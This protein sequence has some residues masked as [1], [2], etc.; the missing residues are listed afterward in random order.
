MAAWG[1][2]ISFLVLKKYCTHSLCS[3]VKYF[4][5]LKEKF[6]IS[7]RQCTILYVYIFFSYINITLSLNKAHWKSRTILQGNWKLWIKVKKGRRKF[8]YEQDLFTLS[9]RFF[10]TQEWTEKATLL[11]FFFKMVLNRIL[12]SRT[13]NVS[14]YRTIQKS[15]FHKKELFVKTI[16]EKCNNYSCCYHKVHLFCSCTTKINEST[17]LFL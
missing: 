5:T 7:E 1:Y 12:Q 16:N 10:E 15:Y 14:D 9:Y 17:L 8:G 2:K 6:R 11:L 4:S 13:S 3:F